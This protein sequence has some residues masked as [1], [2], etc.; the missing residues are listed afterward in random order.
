[1]T[2]NRI[3][4]PLSP[5]TN[6]ST[7]F[8]TKILF[9]IPLICYRGRG[10]KGCYQFKKKGLCKHTLSESGRKRRAR[11][12][13]YNRY[14]VDLLH[15]AKRAD[16]Q[17]PTCGISVY[18]YVPI[19]KSIP[20]WRRK[21][22]DG[23]MKLSKPDIKN[24]QTAFEDALAITDE[25]IAQYSGM[26]KFWVDT[27]DYTKPRGAAVR[28]GWIEILINQPVYNPF[29]VTFI[30]EKTAI[31]MKDEQVQRDKMKP[32]PP[33]TKKRR[34]NKKITQSRNEYLKPFREKHNRKILIEQ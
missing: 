23:Q 13:K 2:E 18:F 14:K 33:P 3:I 22:M 6:V 10:G 34:R 26:G 27:R 24:Y 8:K 31:K 16:F 32:K 1:M 25:Q 29:G 15:W 17:L 9:Q 28:Q 4:L 7:T 30:D 19:A 21:L 5:Q 11:L 20:N 12:E